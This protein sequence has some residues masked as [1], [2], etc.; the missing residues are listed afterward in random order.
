MVAA[1]EVANGPSALEEP[2]DCKINPVPHHNRQ[3][4]YHEEHQ[5]S[6]KS[7]QLDL[8]KQY[9]TSE[10]PVSNV[11]TNLI[12]SVINSNNAGVDVLNENYKRPKYTPEPSSPSSFPNRNPNLYDQNHCTYP[13]PGY[14]PQGYP[15]PSISSD[16]LSPRNLNSH[17]TSPITSQN[18]PQ[19]TAPLDKLTINLTNQV[20]KDNLA[21]HI[22]TNNSGNRGGHFLSSSNRGGHTP[23]NIRG[24]SHATVQENIAGRN[25]SNEIASGRSSIGPL[26]IAEE[27]CSSTTP[28]TAF[29]PEDRTI[30][31]ETSHDSQ[32]PT[33]SFGIIP[34]TINQPRF[35]VPYERKRNY[36]D[37][38]MDRYSGSNPLTNSQL[39]ARHVR[40]PPPPSPHR[41]NRSQH[42]SRE[43]AHSAHAMQ[44]PMDLPPPPGSPPPPMSL[45]PLPPLSHRASL[46]TTL[47]PS[48]GGEP[49]RGRSHSRQN[50]YS[51]TGRSRLDILQ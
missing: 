11:T 48:I 3:H 4:S 6:Q 32:L 49:E 10:S 30:R 29:C 38:S 25:E 40:S 5:Q 20:I 19:S 16:Q 1:V 24:N 42:H 50:S 41:S 36:N 27:D 12:N 31:H 17:G 8:N 34:N 13:P 37:I 14:P 45:P 33:Q 43:S 39:S 44:R 46:S 21:N 28:N 2:E 35:N 22:V 26:V 47:S 51:N 23:G 15:P 9:K 18:F 7:Q